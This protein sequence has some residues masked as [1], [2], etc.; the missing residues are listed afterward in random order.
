[1]TPP[2]LDLARLA[3]AGKNWRWVPRMAVHPVLSDGTVESVVGTIIGFIRSLP[4]VWWPDLA[5]PRS[6]DPK[7]HLLPDLADPATLGCVLALVREAWGA[8]YASAHASRTLDR[9][10]NSHG[11][12]WSIR[13]HDR[14]FYGLTEAEALITALD[15]APA[16]RSTQ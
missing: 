14:T 10:F 3:V 5:D 12:V 15:S 1:M 16:A 7:E 11:W 13:L 6:H 8:P 4:V 9:D 2:S